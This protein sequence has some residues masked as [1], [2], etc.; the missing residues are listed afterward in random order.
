MSLTPLDSVLWSPRHFS[1]SMEE[2]LKWL[3]SWSLT[4]SLLMISRNVSNP[5]T[6]EQ[7]RTKQASVFVYALAI[8][9]SSIN[10]QG[11][12]QKNLLCSKSGVTPIK[13]LRM[14]RLGL[15]A[16]LLLARLVLKIISVIQVQFWHVILWSD[17]MIVMS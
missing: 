13:S 10:R 17:T 3:K 6:I 1:K 5:I 7:H 12:Q 15:S 8:Y 9:F 2:K 14:L 16:V 11:Q 4:K